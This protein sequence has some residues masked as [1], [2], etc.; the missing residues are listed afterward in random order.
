[1]QGQSLLVA[2][3]LLAA[4]FAL[5]GAC[6]DD[7]SHTTDTDT[8]PGVPEPPGESPETPS[9][10][11]LVESDPML[12]QLPEGITF[13]DGLIYTAWSATGEVITVDPAT[14]AVEAYAQI[15]VIPG[16]DFILG[17]AAAPDGTIYAA[18][19]ANPLED[20]DQSL[21]AVVRI[22]PPDGNG[23]APTVELFGASSSGFT[24]PNGVAVAPDGAVFVTDTTEGS[25]YRI[26]PEGDPD[27]SEPWLRAP[28]LAGNSADSMFCP[29][30]TSI[31][32][33]AGANGIVVDGDE[34]FVGVHDQAQL[35]RVPILP[36][37]T[38]GDLEVVVRDCDLLLEFDGLALDRAD[39]GFLMTV[40]N[41]VRR[42]TRDGVASEVLTGEVFDE[43]ANIVQS[44]D[45]PNVF[46][47]V[48]VAFF[49]AQESPMAARPG[50]LRLRTE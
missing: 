41:G 6:G 19:A 4:F 28:E 46:F 36:D 37:G 17:M 20:P 45:D 29:T 15:E 49:S 33:L 25:I 16:L 44:G 42:I 31:P 40:A 3:A 43:S 8:G 10:E 23:G 32:L 30:P 34:V 22:T 12:G 24:F 7:D 11:F 2:K 1:M 13:Y 26:P 21:G 9:V 14:G 47:M 27:L 35:V 48:N 18:R 39:G 38:A 50:V 5:A